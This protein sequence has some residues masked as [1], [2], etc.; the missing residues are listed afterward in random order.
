[1]NTVRILLN[2]I[3]KT[4]LYTV[5]MVFITEIIFKLKKVFS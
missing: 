2:F 1:M 3:E 5:L 4:I